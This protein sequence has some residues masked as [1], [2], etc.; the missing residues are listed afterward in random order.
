MSNPD[1][2]TYT[3][4]QRDA[5]LRV[6]GESIDHGLAHGAA[7]TIDPD[8][9]DEPLRRHR[10]CFV[11]LHLDGKLR[12]CIGSLRAHRPLITDIAHNAFA[13]AFEDPRFGALTAVERPGLDVHIS[14][15]S[16]PEP[17]AFLGEDGL[18]LQLRPGVDG[19]IIE[20][21]GGPGRGRR[22]TFLPA[23]WET[24]PDRRVF[25][26]HLKAKAGLP[27]GHWSPT[28][29]AWRYTATGVP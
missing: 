29:R 5:M 2:T 19:L 23:V 22:A 17:I 20:E 21:T 26:D 15:L 25:L 10:A 11:T 16:A 12:G 7:A 13:A 18:L 28:M 9:F 3:P 4:A 24:L 14:V 27:R 8:R 6:A 1:D